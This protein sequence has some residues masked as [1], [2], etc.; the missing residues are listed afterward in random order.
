MLRKSY[1][2]I[3]TYGYLLNKDS[4]IEIIDYIFKGKPYKG[5]YK[6]FLLYDNIKNEETRWNI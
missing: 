2:E 1:F 6:D 4:Q 5:L 3:Q